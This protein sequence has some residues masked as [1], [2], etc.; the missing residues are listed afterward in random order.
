[1]VYELANRLIMRKNTIRRVYLFMDNDAAGLK[2]QTQLLQLLEPHSMSIGTMNHVYEEF[3][4]LSDH[5]IKCSK[6]EASFQKGT[7]SL[8]T[9]ARR[10]AMIIP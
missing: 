10:K 4:D 1:M 7:A 8:Q 2:A 5:W 6:L 3:K 9:N